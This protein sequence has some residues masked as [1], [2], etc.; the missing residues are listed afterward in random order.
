MLLWLRQQRKDPP[1]DIPLHPGWLWAFVGLL[2]G[3][4][5]LGMW[6]EMNLPQDVARQAM[7]ASV[8]HAYE[9][10]LGIA[11]MIGLSASLLVRWRSRY[12]MFVRYGVYWLVLTGVCMI[13]YAAWFGLF[14]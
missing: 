7:L 3:L 6:M 13:G 8:E 2:M 4:T 10:N 5:A 12:G 11:L 9:R 14:W 1:A